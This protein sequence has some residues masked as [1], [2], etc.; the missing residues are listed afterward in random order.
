MTERTDASPSGG[1]VS[2][3]RALLCAASRLSHGLVVIR[4]LLGLRSGRVEDRIHL[5]AAMA[6]LARAHDAAGGWGVSAG[7]YFAS[8]WLPPYPETTGYII[9]TAMRYAEFADDEQWTDR[10][11][12]MGD[13]EI[14]VQLP[15][16]GVRGQIGLNDF[17]IVFNTGQVTLGWVELFLNTS[18][19]K[20]L[21]AAVRAGDWL[22]AVQDV[23]GKWSTSDHAGVPHAYQSRVAWPLFELAKAS[24]NVEYRRSAE[25]CIEWV[26]SKV[27]PNGWIE[28]MA[29]LPGQN[30][31]THTIVYTLR[32]LLESSAYLGDA[33]RGR[34]RGV[35]RRAAETLLM[36]YELS[37]RDPYGPPADLP[38]QFDEH[39]RPAAKYSC[40][41]GDCQ[42]SI[43]WHKLYAMTGDPRFTNAALKL[44]DQVKATQKL[45]SGNPGIR[46]A[47][48]G[49]C[50][51]WGGYE[52]FGYPNWAA[53]FFA[54][55]IMAQ[56]ETLAQI[57]GRP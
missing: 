4:D 39:W 25:K 47:I 23:D 10:A 26:L 17:P 41:T 15:G 20:Y 22:C 35:V 28:H 3:P 6:W 42:L 55:A 52:R 29:F 46:G 49:S 50:P 13:W 57:G 1:R 24:G 9:G 34:V 11:M 2:A 8:G 40:L 32:G 30:P 44:M 12:R 54:D 38:G 16:G 36:N 43:L 51:I 21:D 33:D 14:Q 31:Y 7:Y 27:Q 5:Q 19:Q 18:E 45:R 53:K 56:E 37:K 48:A